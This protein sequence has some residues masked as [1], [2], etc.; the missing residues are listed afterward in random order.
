M[1]L[2]I[3]P[4]PQTTCPLHCG[5]WK[6][7]PKWAPRLPRGLPT[8]RVPRQNSPVRSEPPRA[9]KARDESTQRVTNIWR[10]QGSTE[11]TRHPQALYLSPDRE[12]SFMPLRV[13]W[14]LAVLVFSPRIT[15]ER[16]LKPPGL[17]LIEG[18]GGHQPLSDPMER[19]L[20]WLALTPKW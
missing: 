14:R 3:S 11:G 12:V 2:C 1:S 8:L 13:G 7:Y 6:L 18:G 5:I 15:R 10:Y 16:C 9:T 4:I 19:C 17:D 20:P